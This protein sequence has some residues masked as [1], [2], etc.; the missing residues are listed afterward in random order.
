[1]PYAR[2]LVPVAPSLAIA[3]VALSLA[4][5]A[6]PVW[7]AA[8]LAAALVLGVLLALRAAPA[9]RSVQHDRADLIV[10]ARPVLA[11]AR[12]VAALD[13]GWVSAATDA[14]IVDLAGLTDPSIALLPGGHTSKRVDSSMLLDRSVDTVLVYSEMRVV[15]ARLVGSE[16]FT[17][18]FVS[19][20]MLPLGSRGAFYVVYR[21]RLDPRD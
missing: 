18:R 21:A 7:S 3:F 9:G 4:P 12:V 19:A 13:I 5:G 6:R 8:R 1:M 16:L 15:E 2:L 17:R 11:D 20:E 10:R 14:R